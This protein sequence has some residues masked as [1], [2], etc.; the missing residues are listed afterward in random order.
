MVDPE[1]LDLFAED[2]LGALDDVLL[3]GMDGERSHPFTGDGGE[4]GSTAA[5]G[6]VAGADAVMRSAAVW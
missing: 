6:A 5:G 3:R 1:E 2:N 4:G